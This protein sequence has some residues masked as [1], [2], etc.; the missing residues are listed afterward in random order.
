MTTVS[1]PYGELEERIQ[2]RFKDKTLI[3]LALVHASLNPAEN[4]ERLEFLGDAVLELIISNWLYEAQP[5]SREGYLTQLRTRLVSTAALSRIAEEIGLEN[6]VQ[7]GKSI[8]QNRSQSI[9]DA[10]RANALEALIGAVFLDDGFA[11]AEFVIH[12]IFFDRVAHL[13]DA[14]SDDLKNPKSK[15]QELTQKLNYSLPQY[16][17][18]QVDNEMLFECVCSVEHL[19]KLLKAKARADAKK[20]AEQA[21]AEKLLAS[22]VKAE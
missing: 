14:S 1:R 15:L 17:T 9:S 7:F 19:D 21:A 2:Y 22:L 12:R 3:E 6:F 16:S 11:S 10:I 20:K 18:K 13:L 4:N 8:M 5:R